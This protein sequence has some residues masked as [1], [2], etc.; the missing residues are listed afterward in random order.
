M[1]RYLLPLTLL[2]LLTLGG[3]VNES[4]SDGGNSN[5]ING[6][7]T[8]GEGGAQTVN[9]S[10]RVPDGEHTK[11]VT[12]VNGSIHISPNAVVED[13]H[14][15]NGSVAVG[16]HAGADSVETVNG[17]ISLDPGAHVTR[18]VSTVNG[19]LHLM[20]AE[21]GGRLSN[22]NGTIDL[23]A[24]HV[25][26]GIHTINGDID[27]GSNSRVEG[28]I[29]VEKPAP[30]LFNWGNRTP[31]VV[32]GPG[33]VVQGE[34]RFERQVQLYVSDKATIGT[35]TGASPIRFTGDRPPG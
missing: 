12:T 7:V 15:V 4:D 31:R 23:K 29:L 22:V 8:A 27:V 2:A 14:T 25:G 11:T 32:I 24:A 3:C 19:A 6:S 10:I 21:V 9:G 26:G 33:A 18:S 30:S 35:V 1:P 34:L 13:A 16:E 5:K 17:G 20:D 28:G